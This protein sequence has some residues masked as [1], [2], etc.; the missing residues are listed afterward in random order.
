MTLSKGT[1]SAKRKRSLSPPKSRPVRIRK[2]AERAAATAAEHATAPVRSHKAV[3]RTEAEEDALQAGAEIIH[4][5]SDG[6]EDEDEP[7]N[8]TADDVAEHTEPEVEED[9]E[10]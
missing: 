4:G 7:T 6:S 10:S 2:L 5:H 3:I 8:T 9:D 1:A